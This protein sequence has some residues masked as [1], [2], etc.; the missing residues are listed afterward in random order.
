M[1]CV[2]REVELPLDA[3]EAWEAVTELEEW[4]VDDADLALEPGEEGT[5]RLPGGEERHTVVEEVT[6]RERLAFW[7]SADGAPATRVELTLV[8]AIG[9][10]VVRVVESGFAAGPMAIHGVRPAAAFVASPSLAVGRLVITE[11]AVAAALPR[12]AALMPA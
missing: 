8:P 9:G 6:P 3:G 12:L 10:T 2:T 7:W 5:L 11:S 4:L 1:S